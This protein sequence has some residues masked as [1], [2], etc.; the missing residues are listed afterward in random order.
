MLIQ[1]CIVLTLTAALSAWLAGFAAAQEGYHGLICRGVEES[2]RLYIGQPGFGPHLVSLFVTGPNPLSATHTLAE[3]MAWATDPL[4]SYVADGTGALVVW[5]HPGEG[6]AERIL[7]L[8]GL[9]GIELSYGGDAL[10]REALWDRLLTA[11]AD[12]GRP[13]LWG[14]ADDDTHS[15][16]NANLSWFAAR[17]PEMSERALKQALREG[18]FYASNGPYIEDVQ[19]SDGTISLALGQEAEVLWLRAGQHLA[20]DPDGPIT[21]TAEPGPGRCLQRDQG[22]TRA[23]F[24]LADAGL[25]IADLKF[26][27]A[28]VRTNGSHVA[29]TQPF[30]V[31]ADGTIANPYLPTGQWVRGQTHNHTDAP[32]GDRT[33]IVA[34]RLAYQA[35]GQLASFSTDY[36][37]WETPHQWLPED[38]TPRIEAVAPDRVRAGE[39]VEAIITGVNLA[40][41]AEVLIAGNPLP[42]QAVE[43]S[44]VV[45]VPGDLPVGIHDLT[46]TNP[47]GFRDTL[48]QGFTVQTADA[49][50]AGW[51]HWSM[52][53]GLSWDQCIAVACTGDEAWVGTIRGV[54]H[55][56]GTA[57]EARLD[58]PGRS[59]YA[60]VRGPKGELWFAT[61]GGIA[62]LGPDGA[63]IAH[64]VG[65][66]E[67]LARASSIERWG[68]LAFDAQG[69]LWAAHRWN[70]GI[71]VR[72]ADGSWERLTTTA[73]GAPSNAPSAP[74]CDAGGTLWMGFT[75]G[76]YRL[77]GGEWRPV[78][79]PEELAGC[80]FVIAL[81]PASDGGMW[82]AVTGSPDAGG[83]VRFDA[84]G[85]PQQTLTPADSPLPSTRI[86][87]IL[88]THAGEVWFASDLGIATLSP[89]G[90]WRSITSLTSGLGSNIVL[91]LAEDAS[92]RV[93][94]A[95]ARGVSRYDAGEG[96]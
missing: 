44:L 10:S 11:C 64:A 36:S 28:V 29:Q 71:G 77:T 65:Q 12:Q 50:T 58:V 75:N 63:W 66:P 73:G 46:V 48:A 80:R 94:C 9:T 33:R 90:T 56:D 57:W 91:D 84:D 27:R 45:R 25:P 20:P 86:R 51:R 1:R 54:S 17:L 35:F 55:W 70:G 13:F 92:G 23:Q 43:G 2:G 40:P 7:A 31:E 74:A 18:N 82:A 24:R 79:L 68:R 60:I 88:V 26:I 37:Y 83:V 39:A 30:R 61:G 49:S 6:D 67:R 59:V 47:D 32:P 8:E 89:D 14:Y 4:H 41:G 42:A 96:G 78:A 52:A 5:A 22:V 34:Y 38:G 76:L 3:H 85:N 53:N 62:Q 81:E 16:E 87:D 19:V 72:H 21:V 69:Q 95:T 15:Y 93:W